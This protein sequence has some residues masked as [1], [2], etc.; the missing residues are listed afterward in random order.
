MTLKEFC[1]LCKKL[2]WSLSITSA[3]YEVKTSRQGIR[4]ADCPTPENIDAA[5]D[6]IEEWH[7][8]Q[9]DAIRQARIS[10]HNKVH[11][12]G[13]TDRRVWGNGQLQ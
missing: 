1:D 6:T 2:D 11:G 13:R 7:Q 3:S 8:V 5:L 9:I 12:S 4:V 10:A